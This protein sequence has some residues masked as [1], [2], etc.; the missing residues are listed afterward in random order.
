MNGEITCN[1]RDEK[2][3]LALGKALSSDKRLEILGALEDSSMNI[4]EIAERLQLPQS[5]AAMHVKVLEEAGLI[6]TELMPGVRGS[7]KLCR[8]VLDRIQVELTQGTEEEHQIEVIRMPIG[9][10]VDYKVVPTCGMV[11]IEGPLDEEDEPRCFYNPN[12]TFAQLLW[13]G[14]GHVEYRFPNAGLDETR[15]KKIEISMELCSEAP[16]FNLDWP[17][18]ITLWINDVEAGTWKCPSDFGG[19]KGKLNPDW[20][21]DD[22]TQY[23]KLKTWAVDGQMSMLDGIKSSDA[24]LSDYH[25]TKEPYVSV[26]IGI[27]EESLHHGGINVFG[28]SFGDYPQNIVMKLYYE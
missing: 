24:K 12:R 26:R 11:G 20:W 4:N 18:D 21:P 8:R 1:L 23:G 27:K 6:K 3:L 22:K 9:N 25:L 13:L 17:S 10:Y 28:E 16:D 5:S 19:R 15:L 2:E 14:D 7:M